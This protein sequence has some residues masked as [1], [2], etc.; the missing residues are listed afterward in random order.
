[1]ARWLRNAQQRVGLRDDLDDKG[2]LP[3]S[4]KPS[5]MA[6]KAAKKV[7]GLI[8]RCAPVAHERPRMPSC[9]PVCYQANDCW[10]ALLP[11]M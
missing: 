3:S 2:S 9:P 6:A 10:G 8:W 1:M 11:K 7:R 5:A 4:K